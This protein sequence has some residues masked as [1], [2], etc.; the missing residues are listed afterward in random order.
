MLSGAGEMAE[1]AGINTLE[2]YF[3]AL[4]GNEDIPEEFLL[5]NG[6]LICAERELVEFASKDLIYSDY[7]KHIHFPKELDAYKCIP[8]GQLSKTQEVQLKRLLDKHHGSDFLPFS[9]RDMS[10]LC[11]KGGE[12][13]GCILCGFDEDNSMITLMELTDFSDDPMCVAKL[14]ITLGHYVVDN[15]QEETHAR[16]LKAEELKVA[17]AEKLL[18]DESKLKVAGSLL[19]GVKIIEAGE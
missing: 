17:L 4:W 2:I 12:E 8:L 11:E 10:F 14:L 3:N 13:K 15:F 1:A 9:N 5:E 18:G 19:H 16:F 7:V 6:F